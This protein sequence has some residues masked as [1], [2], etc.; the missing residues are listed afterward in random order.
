MQVCLQLG[1]VRGIGV[2]V[3][4]AD[5]TKPEWAGATPCLDVRNFSSPDALWN[6]VVP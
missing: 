1:Q 4:A 6:A 3:I 2:E 5:T